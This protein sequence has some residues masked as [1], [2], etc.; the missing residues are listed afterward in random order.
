M[1]SCTLQGLAALPLRRRCRQGEVVWV[2][3]GPVS[4]L[5]SLE[6]EMRRHRHGETS[7]EA[8]RTNQPSPRLDLEPQRPEVGGDTRVLFPPRG[9]GALFR[10]LSRLTPRRAVGYG[11]CTWLCSSDHLTRGAARNVGLQTQDSNWVPTGLK[12]LCW[13]AFSVRAT[14]RLL[15]GVAFVEA[16]GC[17]GT[18]WGVFPAAEGCVGGGPRGFRGGASLFR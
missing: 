14:P 8:P 3:P 10:R 9:S 12:D 13:D 2:G 6:G 1:S 18:S 17:C 7:R 11:C 15:F 16:R 5:S 4:P